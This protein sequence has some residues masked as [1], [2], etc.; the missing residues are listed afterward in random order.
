MVA[1]TPVSTAPAPPLPVVGSN[2]L[3]CVSDG[4]GALGLLPG[5]SCTPPRACDCGLGLVTR[6]RVALPPRRKSAVRLAADGITIWRFDTVDPSPL[7]ER[8]LPNFVDPPVAV[9]VVV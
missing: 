3:L 2:T 9:S 5:S 4:C 7:T 6:I 8:T 1:P